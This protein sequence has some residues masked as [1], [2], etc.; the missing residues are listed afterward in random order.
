MAKAPMPKKDGYAAAE[1]TA[2]A[3]QQVWVFVLDDVEYRLALRNVP[4]AEQVE[5]MAQTP[6]TWEQILASFGS[7][8]FSSAAL[9]VIVW[10]ARRAA[11]ESKLKWSAFTAEWDETIDLES[12]FEL[13]VEDAGTSGESDPEA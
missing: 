6:L 2:K 12:S 3:N 13:R 1:V 8:T 4:V 7:D 5:V 9:S 10:L 11:G